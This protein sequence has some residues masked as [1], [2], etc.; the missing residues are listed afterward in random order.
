MAEKII[1]KCILVK[2]QKSICSYLFFSHTGHGILLQRPEAVSYFATRGHEPEVMKEK[3]MWHACISAIT[4]LHSV[5]LRDS[6]QCFFYVIQV[7]LGVTFNWIVNET[8]RSY[9]IFKRN[10]LTWNMKTSV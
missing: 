7:T 9:N 3:N 6:K 4:K 5:P 1:K 2:I 8:R 10:S